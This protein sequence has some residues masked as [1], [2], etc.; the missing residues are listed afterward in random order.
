MFSSLKLRNFRLYWIGTFVSLIG[1]WIQLVAQSWLV[2][3]L[4]N[5]AFLLGLVGFLSSIPVFLLSLFGGVVADRMNKRIIL[6]FT[7]SA[8]MLLAFALALLTHFELVA[9]WQIMLI[10]ALNGI[11][12]SFDAP[13]RQA[14]VMDLVGRERIFNAVALNS[15][16]FNSSRILGPALAALLI[17]SVGMSGCFYLNAVSYLPLIAALAWIN[18]DMLPRAVNNRSVAKD[19]LEGLNCVKNNRLVLVLITM[20]AISS[21][22]GVS[23][24]ILM[25][26][27][28]DRVLKIGASG[29][30]M[31][32]SCVGIG[33][34]IAALLLV[35]LG[36]YRHKGRLLVLSS[37]VFS[38]GLVLFSL[39]PFYLLSGAA[40]VLIG[41]GSITATAIIN[42]LLQTVVEDH[43]RGRVMS[44]FMFTFVGFMPFGNLLAGML[45]EAIGVSFTLLASGLVC[46]AFFVLINLLYPEIAR[47]K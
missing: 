34:L 12:M 37:L 22:F 45:S 24:V 41:W 26:V 16:A 4:T 20:V 23:Y 47:Q 13:T 1:T 7:Q 35:G 10:A 29:L 3:K 27:V 25:P 11:T 32:M 14:V 39:S 9:A 42:T 30:A 28:A 36:D 15:V 17:S 33:A 40:L 5:S 18:V 6:I 21:L 31:L 46:T 44:V 19:L 43:F 38:L 2:F 8:F